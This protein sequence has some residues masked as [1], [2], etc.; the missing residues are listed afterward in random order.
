MQTQI[1]DQLPLEVDNAEV[2]LTSEAVFFIGC[3]PVDM[4]NPLDI[5]TLEEAS[6][7]QR[8]SF[9]VLPKDPY[10]RLVQLYDEAVELVRNAPIWP[11][12]G[13]P[14]PL[15]FRFETVY[16]LDAKQQRSDFAV[17]A[18]VSGG[19][20]FVPAGGSFGPAERAR[21]TGGAEAA[22][23]LLSTASADVVPRL[24]RRVRAGGST[25]SVGTLALAALSSGCGLFR[26]AAGNF[27]A[28]ERL[29]TSGADSASPGALSYIISGVRLA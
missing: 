5:A 8:L 24:D 13:R 17:M 2:K 25:A 9:F 6:K 28:G 18:C 19:L 20:A 1:F 7:D 15:P 29:A 26:L 27:G 23:W 12:E 21:R 3:E 22:H 4:V 16:K 11:E 14:G 10:D